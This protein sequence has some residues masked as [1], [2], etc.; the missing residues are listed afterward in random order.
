[1]ACPGP[2][3][4]LALALSRRGGIAQGFTSDV[5]RGSGV[6][7]MRAVRAE[8]MRCS[9][10]VSFRRYLIRRHAHRPTPGFDPKQNVTWV[11]S[12]ARDRNP[13]LY[14][15]RRFLRAELRNK[16][17]WPTLLFIFVAPRI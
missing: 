5:R 15:A 2:V 17:V 14:A 7:V 3:P 6:M 8:R 12:S 4:S 16:P 13:P 10:F 11:E 1:M 9:N